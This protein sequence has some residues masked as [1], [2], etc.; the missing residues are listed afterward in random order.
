MKK[1]D[2]VCVVAS[3]YAAATA[4]F[5]C[6]PAWF[7]ITLPRYYPVEHMWKMGKTP[8]MIS[9]GWYGMQ[10]FAYLA[11]AVVAVITYFVLKAIAKKDLKPSTI[12]LIG[13]TTCVVICVCMAYIMFHE[14]QKWGII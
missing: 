10:G 1:A 11:A 4:F 6:F 9:Q 8:D 3:V 14:F 5:Y 12:K 2:I 13:L 7:G